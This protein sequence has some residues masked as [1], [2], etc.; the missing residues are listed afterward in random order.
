LEDLLEIFKT[1]S[2]ETRLRILKLLEHGELCVCD[3]VAAL[4][5]IQP[6]V[7]FHLGVMKEAKLIKDRRQGKWI[8]YRIDDTDLFRRFLV[9]TVL[10]KISEE[11]VSHDK[12]RLKEFLE[13]KKTRIIFPEQIKHEG[14]E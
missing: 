14:G 13:N 1:L 3:I 12:T 4:D 11:T 10:E 2:D 9:L 7:S 5:L 8:H 6:K